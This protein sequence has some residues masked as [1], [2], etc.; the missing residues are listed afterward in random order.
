MTNTPVSLLMTT[1]IVSVTPDTLLEVA[2]KMFVDQRIS[3]VPVVDANGRGLGVL[4]QTDLLR[5]G[6][7]QPAS[8]AG[9]QSLELPAEPVKDHMHPGLVTVAPDAQVTEAARIMVESRIHRVFVEE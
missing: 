8:L 3:C 6:R 2:Y 7:L 5:V 9:M 1:P 4:S